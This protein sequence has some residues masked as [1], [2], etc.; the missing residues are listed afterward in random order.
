M[1][2]EPLPPL[3]VRL[4]LRPEPENVG[5]WFL[6]VLSMVFMLLGMKSARAMEYGVPTVILLAGYCIRAIDWKWW[7]PVNLATLVAQQGDVKRALNCGSS[8]FN[9]MSRSAT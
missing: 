8:R 4:R 5:I 2:S 9:S 6:T 3:I 1:K 7:L